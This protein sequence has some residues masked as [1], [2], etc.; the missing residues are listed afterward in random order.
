MSSEPPTN[1]RRAESRFESSNTPAELSI[2]EGPSVTTIPSTVVD[3]SRSG[4]KVVADRRIG[5]GQQV[6]I[7][8]EKLI[9]FG[10]VRH[11]RPVATGFESGIK[12]SDVIS[13]RGVCSRLTEEQI[14]LLVLGR[15]LSLAERM[16]AKHHARHCNHCSEQLQLTRAFFAKLQSLRQPEGV[17]GTGH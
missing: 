2:I 6:R 1:E 8:M 5:T 12:I 10:D 13:A 15:G 7:K 3:I 11:C 17:M 4:L 9:V 14:E 16:Y